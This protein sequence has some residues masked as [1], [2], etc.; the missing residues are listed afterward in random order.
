MS[1]SSHKPQ[2]RI[3]RSVPTAQ[4]TRVRARRDNA[5]HGRGAF[6]PRRR[7]PKA[8]RTGGTRCR[9]Q[10]HF[11]GRSSPSP[12]RN[13]AR[14]LLGPRRIACR[15]RASLDSP[16]TRPRVRSWKRKR[17]ACTALRDDSGTAGGAMNRHRPRVL[18]ATAALATVSTLV[19]VAA[20][21]VVPALA[22]TLATG[23]C[24]CCATRPPRPPRRWLSRSF[25][26]V[27][28]EGSTPPTRATAGF[29]SAAGKAYHQ[30]RA[31]TPQDA[32]L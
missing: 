14:P 24:M 26:G 28:R 7:R 2:M 29:E 9:G 20:L 21:I 25:P 5:A 16:R 6:L 8:L 11:P 4:A 15:L 31:M 13:S 3:A 23:T 12:D 18:A 10:H 17:P 19:L 27:R 22:T 1:I 30:P 32:A